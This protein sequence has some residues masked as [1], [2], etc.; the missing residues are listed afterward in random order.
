MRKNSILSHILTDSFRIETTK[1]LFVGNM[2]PTDLVKLIEKYNE[3]GVY[4]VTKNYIYFCNGKTL[5]KQSEHKSL[6]GEQF[7][8]IVNENKK[9]VIRSSIQHYSLINSRWNANG[10][11]PTK[12]YDMAKNRLLMFVH[13]KGDVLFQCEYQS[14]RYLFTS[15]KLYIHDL[16]SDSITESDFNGVNYF[17]FRIKNEL[18]FIQRNFK[19]LLKMQNNQLEF[20][21]KFHF[22][23]ALSS[24]EFVIANV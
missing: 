2:I 22:D 1:G 21:S 11:F 4:I 24:P 7:R 17:A 10:N 18:F 6:E 20:I 8:G 15:T 12:W 23:F 14:K 19:F 9:I 16:V 5:V 3:K 13:H